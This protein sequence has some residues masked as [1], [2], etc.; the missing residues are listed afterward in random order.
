MRFCASGA[1]SLALA[2]WLFATHS[3]VETSITQLVVLGDSLSDDGL[4]YRLTNETIPPASIYTSPSHSF[5]DQYVWHQT[6]KDSG[7]NVTSLAVGGATGELQLTFNM[8]VRA[9]FSRH[10]L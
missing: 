2:V 4:L 10:G 7:L 3:P 8:C 6:V 9:C 5:T 1:V